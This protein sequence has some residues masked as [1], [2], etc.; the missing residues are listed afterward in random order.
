MVAYFFNAKIFQPHK[1]VFILLGDVIIINIVQYIM[2][3][4]KRVTLVV[5][6]NDYKV[7]APLIRLT[8]CPAI[9]CFHAVIFA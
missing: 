4:I 7:I 8:N 1:M 9:D 6:Y 3:I 5:K 2:M